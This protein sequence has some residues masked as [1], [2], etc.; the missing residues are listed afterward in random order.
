MHWGTVSPVTASTYSARS[1]R[2]FEKVNL[3]V[4]SFDGPFAGAISFFPSAQS[5]SEIIVCGCLLLLIRHL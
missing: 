4:F 1:C 5:H 2:C 3:Q